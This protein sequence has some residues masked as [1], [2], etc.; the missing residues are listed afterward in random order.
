MFG[1]EVEGKIYRVLGG[2]DLLFFLPDSDEQ[3]RLDWEGPSRPGSD[4]AFANTA[5]SRDVR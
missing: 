4:E 1:F 5:D 2:G 3:V